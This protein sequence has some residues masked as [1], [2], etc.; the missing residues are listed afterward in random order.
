LPPT[1]DEFGLY[2]VLTDPVAGYESCTEA[3]VE[4]GVRYVQLRMKRRPT[5]EILEMAQR[6]RRL[7]AGSS[8]RLIVNDDVEIARQ[9]GADGVHLGQDDMPLEEA[10][11][12]WPEPGKIF[13]LSTHSEEQEAL[14]RKLAPDYVGVG[15]VYSTP[16]KDKPDPVLG[17]ERTGSIIRNS[18]LTSVAIGGINEENL[19]AVLSGGA[20][21]FCVVRAVTQHPDPKAAILRLQRLWKEYRQSLQD[22]SDPRL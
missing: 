12:L 16:T 19:P 11:Q 13:G 14:A 7:T 4:T 22:S 6:L 17:P 5:S 15:P 20:V 21:N 10:R 2:L 3:A 18:P 1:P 9:S 8:T